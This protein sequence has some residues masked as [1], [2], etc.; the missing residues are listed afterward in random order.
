MVIHPRW[1]AGL[2]TRAALGRLLVA[3]GAIALLALAAG[4][5]MAASLTPSTT[6]HLY[7]T[8]PVIAGNVQSV[9]EHEMVVETEQGEE[10]VLALDSRT[11]VPTDLA[12][13]MQMRAEF[14][15]LDD[16]RFYAKRVTPIRSGMNP[17]R[18][19]AYAHAGGTQETLAQNA[20][21]GTD[22]SQESGAT[23][24]RTTETVTNRPLGAALSAVPATHEYLLASQPLISGRVVAVN[25][26]QLVV[27]TDQ[28]ERVTLAMDSRTMVPTDLAP[29]MLMRVD[30]TTLK[31]GE[32]YARR[33]TP[34]RGMV[35]PSREMASATTS[36]NQ[37]VAASY[38][39]NTGA[40]APEQLAQNEANPP[41]STGEQTQ[42]STT[43]EK[44]LPQTAS[45]QPLLALI[46]LLALS[47]AAVLWIARR[48]LT[49]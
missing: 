28:G 23:P 39:S 5:S 9:N 35:E 45:D 26:H 12:P 24:T 41:S 17:D 40:A 11:V 8:R 4:G 29:G 48:R 32:Y 33:I 49:V 10:V 37:G 18:E 46:G 30:F 14:R 21:Y 3:T 20:A 27:D 42:T 43:E 16:G 7:A 44:S 34:M 2:A 6:D 22:E 31:N 15:V 13:G 38:A 19:L 36:E 47:A 25:D 1:R